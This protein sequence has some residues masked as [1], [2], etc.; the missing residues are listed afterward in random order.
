MDRHDME[1]K[2]KSGTEKRK[3]VDT[4]EKWR[5][6]HSMDDSDVWAKAKR[7]CRF[8]SGYPGADYDSRVA[9]FNFAA[10]YLLA[11]QE[12]GKRIIISED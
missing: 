11:K 10:G 9:F 8:Y 1:D 6:Q 4:F 7:C 12:E 3:L 5:R 2:T